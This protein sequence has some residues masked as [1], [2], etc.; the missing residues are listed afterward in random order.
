MAGEDTALRGEI[1]EKLG[2]AGKKIEREEFKVFLSGKYDRGNAVLSIY[3]G[4]G[5]QDAQDW[6][7]VLLRMYERYFPS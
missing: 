4:A 7:A 1:E 2:S 5:G 3:S 6:A